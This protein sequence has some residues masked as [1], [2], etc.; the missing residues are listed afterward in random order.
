MVF[1]LSCSFAIEKIVCLCF[2]EKA[3]CLIGNAYYQY[4]RDED[5]VFKDETGVQY[6]GKP[7]E[8]KKK[9]KSF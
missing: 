1:K 5:Q 7:V 9:K 2:L 4:N 6:S 8:K 3:K